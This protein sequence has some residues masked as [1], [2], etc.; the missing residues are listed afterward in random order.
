MTRRAP[1]RRSTVP[2]RGSQVGDRETGRGCVR[3]AATRCHIRAA[4]PPVGRRSVPRGLC[5]GFET[6]TLALRLVQSIGWTRPPLTR[7]AARAT[8]SARPVGDGSRATRAGPLART[9]PGCWRRS[10]SRWARSRSRSSSSVSWAGSSA[11]SATSAP[12][13]SGPGS[14][15]CAAGRPPRSSARSPRRSC[16]RARPTEASP[17]M[18]CSTSGCSCSTGRWSPSCPRACGARTCAS[19]PPG[20]RVRP[21]SRPVPRSTRRRSGTA[22]R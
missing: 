12:W 6:L 9:L 8:R 3:V 14:P 15:A 1:V 18:S 13:P 2:D 17:R 11:T 5:D 7:A 4:T 20:R 16:S 22:W 21:T 19:G 10:E